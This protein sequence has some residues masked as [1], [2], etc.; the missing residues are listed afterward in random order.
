MCII[1]LDGI[2]NIFIFLFNI[3]MYAYWV[4][5]ATIK[6]GATK[7]NRIYFLIAGRSYSRISSDLT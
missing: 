6:A 4:S 2:S 1:L 3:G 5:S 7:M